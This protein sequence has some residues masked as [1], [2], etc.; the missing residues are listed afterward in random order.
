MTD[1]KRQMTDL[2]QYLEVDHKG[3]GS[4]DYL[5]KVNLEIDQISKLTR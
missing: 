4:A 1:L 3:Q 2:F 5:I